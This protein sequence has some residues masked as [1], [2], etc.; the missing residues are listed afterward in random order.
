MPRTNSIAAVAAAFLWLASTAHAATGTI[1]RQANGH[2]DF[3]GI[4]QSLSGADF[5][6]EP[7][8]TRVDAPPGAGVVEG[9]FIPYKPEA[10]ARRKKNFDNRDKLD[11]RLKCWTLGTP[12]GI[13][14]PEPFQILQRPGDLTIV[15]EFGQSVRTIFTNNTKHQDERDFGYFLGDSRAHWEKDTLVVDVVD[16]YDETWL[17]RAGNFH[18]DKLHVVER[19][20]Y[21]DANTIEYKA[22][23]DDPDVYTRPWTLSVILYRHREKNFE[24]IENYCFTLP[25]DKFYPYK[26]QQQV[27]PR[28]EKK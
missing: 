5:D 11:P 13:Y 26:P 3:S 2:P 14:F 6:L 28:A 8:G 16:F 19:W 21:L 17:D 10:L 23:L 9:G 7:H 22:T 27:D 25:Y 18:S 24:L 15:F 4:W 12:R 1:P 20:T